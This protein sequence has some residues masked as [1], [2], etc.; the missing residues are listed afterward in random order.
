MRITTAGVIRPGAD[1]VQS[2][3]LAASRFSNIYLGN[4]PIISS[5]ERLK[6]FLDDWTAAE[7]AAAIEL[8]GALQKFKMLDAIEVKGIEAARI[9]IGVGAQNAWAI[10]SK[11]GLVAPLDDDNKPTG[12][13]PYAFL[14][15]DQIEAVTE[16]I[17]QKETRTVKAASVMQPTGSVDEQGFAIWIAVPGQETTEEIEIDTGEFRVIRKAQTRLSINYTELIL[18]IMAAGA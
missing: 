16:R 4:N 11:H 12:P 7:K 2:L 3:G 1:N 17:T 13:C 18:F 8:R 10:M 14:C 6:L 15:W 5:D 9:H